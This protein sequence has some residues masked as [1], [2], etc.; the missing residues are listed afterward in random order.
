VGWKELSEKL[1]DARIKK[2]L[3]LKEL[4]IK[5]NISIE[6]LKKM[7][8]GD[9]SIESPIYMKNYLKRLS[10]VLDLDESELLEDFQSETVTEVS[11]SH[12]EKEEIRSFA[13]TSYYVIVA[14]ILLAFMITLFF[15]IEEELKSPYATLHN[16]SEATLLINNKNLS[17]GKEYDI[18]DDITVTNNSSV[19]TIVEYSGKTFKIKIRSFEVKLHGKDKK[20]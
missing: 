16:T 12:N 14:I 6:K 1:Q 15:K 18:F 20:P 4:S 7:E 9:F 13:N 11:V 17:P 19:V 10:I 2:R 3:S 5:T 8:R